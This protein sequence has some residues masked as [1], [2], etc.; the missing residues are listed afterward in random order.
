MEDSERVSDDEQVYG[1]PVFVLLPSHSHS[2]T[3]PNVPDDSTVQ[4][5]KT[6]IFEHCPGYPKQSG[7]RIIVKGRV[8][9]DDEVLSKIWEVCHCRAALKSHG[10]GLTRMSDPA[11][12]RITH[13]SFGCAPF[14]LVK[15]TSVIS[16]TSNAVFLGTVIHPLAH[17]G[18]D[19][20]SPPCI[21]GSPTSY[22]FTI[23]I[24]SYGIHHTHSREC[25]ADPLRAN[26]TTL[27][28]FC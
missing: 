2:F 5:L 28:R 4:D 17:F 20:R 15:Y 10:I 26:C 6:A 8:L 7:Q 21:D 3:I 19:T 16:P 22:S 1:T 23:V 18:H 9:A 12:K 25:V 13:C 14:C 11:S 24:S 27:E